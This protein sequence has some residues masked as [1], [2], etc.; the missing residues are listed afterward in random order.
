MIFDCILYTFENRI[1]LLSILNYSK[2]MRKN[3]FIS[4]IAT[5]YRT[6][7]GMVTQ[8]LRKEILSGVLRAGAQLKQEELASRFNVSM[9][10]L[11]EALKNLEAEG[12]VNFYPNRGAIVS[13]L[14]ADEAQEIFD[15]RLFL[16]LGALELSIP[17]LTEA[18]IVEAEE[19]LQAADVEPQDGRWSELN[20]HFHEVLYRPAQRPKLLLLIQNMNNNVER[21]MNLYL[22]TMHYQEK[23]QA[24]HWQLLEACRQ[25]NVKQAQEIL[26]AHMMGASTS[27]TGYLRENQK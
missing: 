1:D 4:P 13:E 15:I 19:L 26:R 14:S 7:S 20:W 12:L 9:S 2:N 21:Y 18:D 8:A 11:R 6:L 23:S 17:R 25:R 27:L 22:S 5:E 24:E 16:E 10:A 3:N